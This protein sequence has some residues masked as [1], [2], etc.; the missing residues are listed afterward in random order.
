MKCFS[1]Y[2]LAVLLTSCLPFSAFSAEGVCSG[3]TSVLNQSDYFMNTDLSGNT[4]GY[5]HFESTPV[6]RWLEYD[7]GA[8][9]VAKSAPG[10]EVG[11]VEL[12]VINKKCVFVVES[13]IKGFLGHDVIAKNDGTI[14][15]QVESNDPDVLFGASL[16]VPITEETELARV[17]K[18]FKK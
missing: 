14:E 11:R 6:G 12:R 10:P 17:S 3:V 4:L 5:A 15:F 9:I 18:R 2:L 16:L 13:G 1:R 8:T 7:N